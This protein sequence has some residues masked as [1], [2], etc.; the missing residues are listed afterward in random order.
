MKESSATLGFN[1]V[2]ALNSI[3]DCE[4]FKGLVFE[5]SNEIC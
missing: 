1:G 2:V 3:Y 5:V 4:V